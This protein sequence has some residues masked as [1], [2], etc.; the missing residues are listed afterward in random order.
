MKFYDIKK[1]T[2]E[3]NSWWA[4]LAQ[5]KAVELAVAK[6]SNTVDDYWKEKW[7]P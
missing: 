3:M 5:V 1:G 7:E 4:Y 6:K 2:I